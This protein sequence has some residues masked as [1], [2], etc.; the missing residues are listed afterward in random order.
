MG[1]RIFS[2][3]NGSFVRVIHFEAWIL[4]VWYLTPQLHNRWSSVL[5]RLVMAPAYQFKTIC[6]LCIHKIGTGLATMLGT[7]VPSKRSRS[8]PSTAMIID[9]VNFPCPHR[10][11]RVETLNCPIPSRLA[12]LPRLFAPMLPKMLERKL[13]LE[14]AERRRNLGVID[15]MRDLRRTDARPWVC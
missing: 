1:A 4:S 9:I 10:T 2:F 14:L 15:V 12:S 5:I 8:L 6:Y 11:S 13:T 7:E 3:A